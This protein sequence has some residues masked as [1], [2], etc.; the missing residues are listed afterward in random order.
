MAT[1]VAAGG[2]SGAPATGQVE[3]KGLKKNAIG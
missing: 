1:E 2:V 3:N